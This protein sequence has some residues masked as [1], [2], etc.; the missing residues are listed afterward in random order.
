MGADN[1]I[2]VICVSAEPGEGG[3][4]ADPELDQ[5]HAGGLVHLGLVRGRV[6]ALPGQLRGVRLRPGRRIEQQ[7]AGGVGEGQRL[8]Q[9]VGAQRPGP[10]GQAVRR[11]QIS[12]QYRGPIAEGVHAGPCPASIR[13]VSP[14]R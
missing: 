8:G 4:R 1:L 11:A 7:H 13:M 10:A 5:D 2:H 9:L 3:L 12:G 6:V 14:L